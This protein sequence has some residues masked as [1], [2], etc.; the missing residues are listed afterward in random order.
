[1]F[2]YHK[3]GSFQSLISKMIM[4]IK[5]CI[6]LLS[7][8]ETWRRWTHVFVHVLLPLL[9]LR[10]HRCAHILHIKTPNFSL[11]PYCYNPAH[12]H[13][14]IRHVLVQFV[15]K[16]CI[17]LYLESTYFFYYNPANI[18][19]ELGQSGRLLKWFRVHSADST[20]NSKH[21]DMI[22]VNTG[23]TNTHAVNLPVRLFAFV[24]V[25]FYNDGSTA[26]CFYG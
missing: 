14:H 10:L 25:R 12:Q 20:D 7:W 26:V 5:S 17:S 4:N 21:F 19:Q 18:C 2:P 22:S 3:T 6:L 8:R 9:L 23:D 1:M 24:E 11:L 16:S 13:P 15:A